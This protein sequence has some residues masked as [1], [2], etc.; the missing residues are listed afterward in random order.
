MAQR[1]LK[2]LTYAF[3]EISVDD[4]NQLTSRFNVEHEE[5]RN[6]LENDLIYLGTF[7]LEDPLR[8]NIHE[9]IMHIRYGQLDA[10]IN[11]GN[12]VNIRMVSGDHLECAIRVALDTG[13]IK[14][15]EY[16]NN[17]G[18]IAMLGKDFREA[19]GGYTK[20]WDPKF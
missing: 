7:G 10:D 17:K 3:K 1:G 11:D 4:L 8:D 14:H 5:F 18:A 20:I 19:I 2:P 12:Q 9:S 16:Q 13:I 15:E 6:E